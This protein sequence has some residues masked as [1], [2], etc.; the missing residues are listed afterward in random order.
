VLNAKSRLLFISEVRIYSSV[1]HVGRGT[2]NSMGVPGPYIHNVR[3]TYICVQHIALYMYVPGRTTRVICTP[4][5]NTRLGERE[6]KE[7]EKKEPKITCNTIIE[8][9]NVNEL[10]RR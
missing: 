7:K 3:V 6:R 10:A 2:T 4:Y 9:R 1:T 8:K 5:P